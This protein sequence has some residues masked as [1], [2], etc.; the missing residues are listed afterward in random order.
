MANFA[1]GYHHSDPA[2]Q[3]SA[4]ELHHIVKFTSDDVP[5]RFELFLL[6]DG[7]QKIEYKEETRTLPSLHIRYIY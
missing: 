4:L 7:Q 1:R 3:R 5:D 6:D 2:A